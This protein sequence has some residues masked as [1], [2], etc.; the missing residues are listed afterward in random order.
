[1]TNR[2]TGG[3]VEPDGPV[4][5]QQQLAPPTQQWVNDNWRTYAR[6]ENRP[7]TLRGPCYTCR[8]EFSQE[9]YQQVAEGGVL[10]AAGAAT[11]VRR[12]LSLVICNCPGRVHEQKLDE[13][14]GCG[15]FWLAML[16]LAADGD[17]EIE[18]YNDYE[19]GLP[20]AM[21]LEEAQTSES[22]RVQGA[23][24]KWL[25]GIATIY[26]L[27]SL[28]SIVTAKGALAGVPSPWKSAIAI[29]FVAAIGTAVGAVIRGYS[30]AYGWIRMVD[31]SSVE[32]QEKWYESRRTSVQR[33]VRGL[34]AA[35]L[36][37]LASISCVV[38]VGMLVWFVPRESASI[39]NPVP[40][41]SP[42]AR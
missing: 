34:H 16:T 42:N 8:H 17:Y 37:T 31:V 27:F 4:R 14:T 36:L 13:P 35:I 6:Q 20:I 7:L 30:A 24:E 26:A 28:V 12:I 41:V 33:S 32:K 3:I 23:A 10:Q 15:R 22:K 19:R 21:A 40:V 2:E 11:P 9:V 38:V 29:V 39:S 25:G 1:M 5:Y 18:V